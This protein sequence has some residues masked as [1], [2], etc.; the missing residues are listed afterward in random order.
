MVA[1]ALGVCWLAAQFG[2]G[3]SRGDYFALFVLD[4]GFKK[5][6]FEGG[7]L[8]AACNPQ[9]LLPAA[10]PDKLRGDV[11]RCDAGDRVVCAEQSVRHGCV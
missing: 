8:H 5:R 7:S 10:D 9:R 4:F 1:G 11:K 6:G 3:L 2:Y